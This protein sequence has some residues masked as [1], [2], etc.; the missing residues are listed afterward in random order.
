MKKILYILFFSLIMS[1][2]VGCNK[3]Q[4]KNLESNSYQQ[5]NEVKDSIETIKKEEATRDTN[6]PNLKE[7]QKTENITKQEHSSNKEKQEYTNTDMNAIETFNNIEKEIDT[8]LASGK[9][10]SI[11]DKAK[12]TFITIVDFIFYDGEIG[13]VKFDELTES[14]KQKILAIA[15]SIDN[16]IENKFPDYKE[17]ISDKAK[18]AFHKASD[19]IKKGANNIKEFSKEKLGED[20][21]NALI[22]AKDDLVYYTKKAFSIVGN[23]VSHLWNTGKDKI[24]NWY[25][26]FRDK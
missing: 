13:G 20:N 23:T 7:Q 18:N 5:Q 17:T 2:L 12:G 6:E 8:L 25:E 16:K 15:N 3:E 22:S 9:S 19:L 10:E 24:K 14:G 4:N 21:Y 11:K 26:N 1:T